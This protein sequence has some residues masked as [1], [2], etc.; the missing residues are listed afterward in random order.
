MA[1]ERWFVE[2]FSEILKRCVRS[3]AC[4]SRICP[5]CRRNRTGHRRRGP[6]SVSGSTEGLGDSVGMQDGVGP[7]MKRRHPRRDWIHER[8][9]VKF[10]DDHG[11]SVLERIIENLVKKSSRPI[12]RQLR[13][14]RAQPFAKQGQAD[15]VPDQVGGD[16][17]FAEGVV[18]FVAAP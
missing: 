2:N 4:V 14:G 17:V 6:D 13:K 5:R 9:L 12:D 16:Q 1:L 8:E 7:L 15:E 18:Q 10:I 11:V 3:A